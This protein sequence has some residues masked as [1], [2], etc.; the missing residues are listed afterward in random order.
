M[1]P[2]QVVPKI[3]LL[4]RVVSSTVST[5]SSSRAS[6]LKK[7]SVSAFS[8]DK[9]LE[10]EGKSLSMRQIARQEFQC[11]KSIQFLRIQ[12]MRSCKKKEILVNA[13]DCSSRASVLEEYSVPAYSKDEILEKEG[14][15]LS[16]RQ[17]GEKSFVLMQEFVYFSVDPGTLKI[18]RYIWDL[19]RSY[20]KMSGVDIDKYSFNFLFI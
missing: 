1:I 9:I 12:K 13:A 10:K 7:S 4:N 6:V 18:Y 5:T 2:A 3:T 14:K 11:W 20:G 15:S 19:F 17:I 8:R 16:M